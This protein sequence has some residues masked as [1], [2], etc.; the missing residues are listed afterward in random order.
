[1]RCQPKPIASIIAKPTPPL[2]RSN[3]NY[4]IPLW[5]FLRAENSAVS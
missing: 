2:P 3:R 4:H 5:F 1:M